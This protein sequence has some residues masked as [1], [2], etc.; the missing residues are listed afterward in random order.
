MLSIMQTKTVK[1]SMEHT[2]GVT[3]RHLWGDVRTG[4]DA[5]ED[6]G[7]QVSRVG[8]QE[9]SGHHNCHGAREDRRCLADKKNSGIG[10]PQSSGREGIRV[11]GEH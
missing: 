8:Q 6:G 9:P 10:R 3:R 5:E 11:E 4:R 2:D 7:E 1:H